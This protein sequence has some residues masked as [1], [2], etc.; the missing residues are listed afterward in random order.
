MTIDLQIRFCASLM[1]LDLEM[2]ELFANGYGSDYDSS[3]SEETSPRQ[4]ACMAKVNERKRPASSLIL[5]RAEALLDATDSCLDSLVA[6]A[7]KR[8]N[9]QGDHE[10]PEWKKPRADGR[11]LSFPPEL[12]SH[13]LLVFIPISLPHQ[14][15]TQLTSLISSIRGREL[16]FNIH[17]LISDLEPDKAL[18]DDP[19]TTT[20]SQV[21]HISLSRALPI[22][23]H[24]V[25]S[26]IQ[27]LK[28]RISAMAAD[29]GPGSQPLT[30]NVCLSS[31]TSFVNDERTRS[32]ASLAIKDVGGSR[33]II[34]K[35]IVAVN[36]TLTMH[37]LQTYY[38]SPQ[39]H[40]SFAWAAGDHKEE[41]GDLLREEIDS[42]TP[43][44]VAIGS[45]VCRI[46]QRDHL[47]WPP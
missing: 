45:I 3:T 30:H 16:P 44:N 17:P 4:D 22:K 35:M 33:D 32:F 28:S 21:L 41:L 46:G 1:S 34:N 20:S 8:Q 18:R 39:L 31:L 25:D 40:V 43:T 5:P 19:P 10:V 23:F 37:G 29:L 7:L 47:I 6:Q 2:E 11:V 27:E 42:F 15:A 36:H 24:L 12:G 38:K 9:G 14:Q 26:L 13:P